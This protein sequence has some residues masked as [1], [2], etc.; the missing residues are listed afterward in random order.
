[1][2]FGIMPV[3]IAMPSRISSIFATGSSDEIVQV[4]LVPADAAAMRSMTR[5]SRARQ[6]EITRVRVFASSSAESASP[7][8]SRS[9]S[10]IAI[11]SAFA[12]QLNVP[13]VARKL[14]RFARPPTAREVS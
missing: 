13:S 5:F 12:E 10:S 7:A 2:R 1:M 3:L 9:W 14:M 8:F 4:A 6:A 11:S